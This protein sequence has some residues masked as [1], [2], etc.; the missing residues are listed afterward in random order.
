MSPKDRQVLSPCN[1]LILPQRSDRYH[2]VPKPCRHMNLSS[3]RPPGAR[4]LA[5]MEHFHCVASW[6]PLFAQG[7]ECHHCP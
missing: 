2:H 7:D 5:Q 4:K 6:P 1:S 3:L